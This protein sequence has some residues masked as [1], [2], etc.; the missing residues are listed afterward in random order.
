[1]RDYISSILPRIQQYSKQLNEEA[2]FV[3]I[4]WGFIDDDG[5]KV[6]YIFRRNSELLVSQ[7]GEVA[8]GHWEY[9]PVVQSMLI[10]YNG[11]KRMYNQGF[12]DKAHN[13]VTSKTYCKKFF[14]SKPCF[15][16]EKSRNFMLMNA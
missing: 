6:T 15:I 13:K 3:E 14:V 8:T 10:E 1:M 9:L 7:K 4:P 11:V 16:H 12:L 2:N 5:N